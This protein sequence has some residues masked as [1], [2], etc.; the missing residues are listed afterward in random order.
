MNHSQL[1]LRMNRQILQCEACDECVTRDYEDCEELCE[2]CDVEKA[3]THENVRQ[4]VTTDT[5]NDTSPSMK[6]TLEDTVEDA[7]E[8]VEDIVKHNTPKTNKTESH[9]GRVTDQ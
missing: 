6:E 2:G 4:T 1:I 3:E 5:Q 9:G 7:L 8:E